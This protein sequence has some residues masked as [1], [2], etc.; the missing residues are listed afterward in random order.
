MYLNQKSSKA[1]TGTSYDW[2]VVSV[3]LSESEA[4]T[5]S[6]NAAQIRVSVGTQ[7]ATSG[8]MFFDMVRLIDERAETTYEYTGNYITAV[9][10]VMG[11]KTSMTRDIRGN[12]VTLT[13]PKGYTSNLEYNLIDQTKAVENP[14]G[15]RTEYVYDKNG[16]VT[17]MT[18][19]NKTTGVILNTTSTQ[20]NEL[21]LV[22]SSTDPLSHT[23]AY[24]YDKNSNMTKINAPNGKDIL[25]TNY[26]NA[27][28]LKNISYVGDS[29]T[30]AF[31]Y[32]RNDNRTSALKNGS[33][34]T[35]YSYDELDRMKKVTFPTNGA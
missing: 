28:R 3:S 13:D 4:K 19:K 11:N 32:D 27:N 24:E 35:L 2:T 21:G 14:A 15:L 8:I 25:Y 23:T 6:P 29:T 20:Y 16:N 10:D 30:W 33:A 1:I 9:T 34:Q 31:D 12:A 17:Q 5:I 18:N 22:K 26:D 7:G